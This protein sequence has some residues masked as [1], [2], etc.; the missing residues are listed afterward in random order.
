MHPAKTQISLGIRPIWSESLNS[1]SAW[2]NLVSLAPQKSHSESSDQ[3]GR[4]PRLIWV[5]AGCTGHSLVLS[6]SG[7]TMIR[8]LSFLAYPT[9]ISVNQTGARKYRLTWGGCK[10]TLMHDISMTILTSFLTSW[11][12]FHVSF[13]QTFRRQGIGE[14]Q[15]QTFLDQTM[16]LF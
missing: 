8:S 7:S 16:Q 11:R 1:L 14:E 6:C 13:C 3:T 4:M 12:Q 2:R 9:R 5:F 10:T 15:Y